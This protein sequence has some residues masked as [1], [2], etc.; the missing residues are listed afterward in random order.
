[1]YSTSNI[2]IIPLRKGVIG[3]GV[4]SKAPI[5][6]A[7]KRVI[8]NSVEIDSDYACMFSENDMGV[9]VDIGDWDEL[10]K[11]IVDLYHSPETVKRMA[12]NAYMYGKEHFSSEKSLKK[13]LNIFDIVQEDDQK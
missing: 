12:E 2:G 9:S 11:V 13:L 3:N 6:M 8:V 10:A 4:P 7:C 5:L 1:M